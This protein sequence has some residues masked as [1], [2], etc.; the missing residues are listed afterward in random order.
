[1]T[2]IQQLSVLLVHAH[3]RLRWQPP[4]WLALMMMSLLA[5]CSAS[6]RLLTFPFD[7]SGRGLNSPYTEQAPQI[8]GRY[9]VFVSDRRNSQDI[10]L[11][12]FVAKRL[13][14]LPG[15]NALDMIAE[16]P[17]ISADGNF[18]VFCGLRQGRSGIYL[19]NRST[20][21]LRN[22]TLNLQAHVRN[23]TIS[24]DG[25]RIA[26]ESSARGQWDIVVYDRFGRPITPP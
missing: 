8:S 25:R 3:P 7:P 15:L 20:G 22:L 13:I 16:H 18:I 17:S 24:A 26:F 9:I 10:Y 4:L 2:G 23:P 1:M 5:S 19:Y 6:T 21:Q 11:Y 14:D 12:D